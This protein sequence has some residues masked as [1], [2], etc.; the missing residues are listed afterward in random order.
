[1]EGINYSQLIQ[2]ILTNHSADDLAKGTEIQLLFDTQRHHYQVLN[3][4]WQDLKRV[5]G[6]IIHVDIKDDKIWI[7]RD[8]TEIGIAEELLAAGVPKDKIV[9]GFQAPYKRPF[10]DFAV[11]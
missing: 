10:T 9:L 2:E 11:S 6:V 1:M 3:I 4:G 8:G 7:Q 5:Y